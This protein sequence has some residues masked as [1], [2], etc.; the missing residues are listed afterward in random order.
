MR[1][2]QFLD[3]LNLDEKIVVITGGGTGLGLE[4]GRDLA[5]AGANI[6][7]AGR[8]P[9]PIEQAAEEFRGMG[10]KYISITTDVTDSTQVNNLFNQTL[11]I[12]N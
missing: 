3:S 4:M 11:E 8:R 10:L 9:E 12:R 7:L 5:R 1:R 6:V 2:W